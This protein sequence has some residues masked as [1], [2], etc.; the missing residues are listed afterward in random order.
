MKG[1]LVRLWFCTRV[2]STTGG[3]FRFCAGQGTEQTHL[4]VS[5]TDWQGGQRNHFTYST[6]VYLLSL[7]VLM[8][9]PRFRC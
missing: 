8:G 2:R 9:T 3:M 1:H 5:L 7:P 4:S 6:L